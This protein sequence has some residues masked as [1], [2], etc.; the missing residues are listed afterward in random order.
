MSDQGIAFKE[1][2]IRSRG[3]LAED[4]IGCYGLVLAVHHLIG[5]Q[6]RLGADRG[7]HHGDDGQDRNQLEEL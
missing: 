5:G 4:F 2:D 6:R 7:Y 3:I 1:D